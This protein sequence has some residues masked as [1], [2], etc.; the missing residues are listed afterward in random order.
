M[1]NKNKNKIEQVKEF[2]VPLDKEALWSAIDAKQQKK[3]RRGFFWLLPGLIVGAVTVFWMYS[4]EGKMDV[5]LSESLSTVVNKV[6]SQPAQITLPEKSSATPEYNLEETTSNRDAAENHDTRKVQV[7]DQ[8]IVQSKLKT[9]R[10]RSAKVFKNESSLSFN[11]AIFTKKSNTPLLVQQDNK[12]NNFLRHNTIADKSLL[13]TFKNSQNIV[14]ANFLAPLPSLQYLPSLTSKLLDERTLTLDIEN[15][16]LVPLKREQLQKRKL[17]FNSFVEAYSGIGI[18]T[19]ELYDPAVGTDS[20]SIIRNTTETPLEA[21][22]LGFK[23]GAYL[24]KNI[25]VSTGLEYSQITERF[26][27]SETMQSENETQNDVI[28]DLFISALGDSLITTGIGRG[29]STFNRNYKIYNR[30]KSYSIPV[31]LGWTACFNKWSL[32]VEAGTQINLAFGFSGSILDSDL[33]LNS[34]PA[35]F[36]SRIGLS[37]VGGLNV[38]YAFNDKFSLSLRPTYKMLPNLIDDNQSEQV[39]RYK[40]FAVGLGLRYGLGNK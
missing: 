15:I 26:S 19:R 14:V 40:I 39:Q 11:K 18:V 6:E 29:T 22:H 10:N 20:Y 36:K 28:T 33:A 13:D 23:Y 27:L 8:T 17:L 1:T 21:W 30:L 3:R 32:G 34:A 24:K 9:N 7:V 12:Q 31:Q 5:G 4:S 2:Q 35:V 37:W 38:A 16:S 25:S